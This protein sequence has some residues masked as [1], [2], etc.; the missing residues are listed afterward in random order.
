MTTPTHTF[1]VAASVRQIMTHAKLDAKL[2]K[3][4]PPV[5]EQLLDILVAYGHLSPEQARQL[6]LF[7]TT[8]G[9]PVPPPLPYPDQ[10]VGK[11]P[12]Y[13]LLRQ[14]AIARSE[15]AEF[16]FVDTIAS[17]GQAIVTVVHVIE[18]VG[19]T[20]SDAWSWLSG[21]FG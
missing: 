1:E 12:L 20:L 11:I 5:L 14:A 9:F 17:I 13:S 21:L 10:A 7:L 19:D 3:L 4:E 16:D 15:S 8:G 2:E 18:Q 6:F